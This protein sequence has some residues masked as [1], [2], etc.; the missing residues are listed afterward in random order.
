MPVHNVSEPQAGDEEEGS[1]SFPIQFMVSQ[2]RMPVSASCDC[3]YWDVSIRDWNE[4]HQLISPSSRQ[5]VMIFGHCQPGPDF[6]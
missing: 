2:L 4:T 6:S 3:V 5:L 1:I